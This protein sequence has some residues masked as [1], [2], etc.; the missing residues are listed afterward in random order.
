MEHVQVLREELLAVQIRLDQLQTEYN[1]TNPTL[2]DSQL[3]LEKEKRRNQQLEDKL[4]ESKRIQMEMLEAEMKR[5][6]M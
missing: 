5:F 3:Q 1:K 2:I 4:M 6:D